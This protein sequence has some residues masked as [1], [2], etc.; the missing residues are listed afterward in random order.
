MIRSTQIARLDGT[1][2]RLKLDSTIADANLQ[3]S[4]FVP[5]SMMNR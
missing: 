3:V 4:C 2:I 5:P 1:T